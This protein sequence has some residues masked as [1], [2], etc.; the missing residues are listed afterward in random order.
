MKSFNATFIHFQIAGKS[1]IQESKSALPENGLGRDSLSS[2]NGDSEGVS[3]IQ[4][5]HPRFSREVRRMSMGMP[6]THF[7][8]LSH[9][10]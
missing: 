2:E 10:Y 8:V 5:G 7:E 1:E 6:I 4:T 9:N 3:G